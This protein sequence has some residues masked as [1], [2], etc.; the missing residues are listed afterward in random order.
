MPSRTIEN[1]LKQLYLAE[2]SAQELP[3][4]MGRLATLMN[5]VPG[6]ATAMVKALAD[7]GLVDYSP[8]T[9][10]QLSSAG[11]KL[12]LHV[13]RRHRLIELFLV[14]IV[15]LDWS[16]VHD[17]AEELEHVISEKLLARID[18][19]LDHPA[20]DPHGDPIPTVGGHVPPES[21]ETFVTCKLNRSVEITRIV[22][23]EPR[24]LQFVRQCKLVPGAR[25][26]VRRRDEQADAV[27]I[28][29]AGNSASPITLSTS[30]AAKFLVRQV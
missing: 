17:E 22:D 27:T 13:L 5:V 9:G 8:R 1:Y 29:L 19:L 21:V 24:F 30:A 18:A 12:A 16:E 2:Q 7:S 20:T 6:T 4:P 26:M 3:I 10:V 23:Q 15:G 25:L 28:D 11:S 14:K